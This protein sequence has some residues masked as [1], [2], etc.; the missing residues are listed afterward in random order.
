[1]LTENK[2]ST[3]IHIYS[4]YEYLK[5]KDDLIEK[6]LRRKESICKVKTDIKENL[7]KLLQDALK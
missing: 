1:M 3:N 4:M 6:H 5:S 2:F 7:D